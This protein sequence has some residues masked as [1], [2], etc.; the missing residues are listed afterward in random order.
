[1]KRWIAWIVIMV[2][3]AAHAQRPEDDSRQTISGALRRFNMAEA[4]YRIYGQGFACRLEQL[5]P[6][7]NGVTPSAQ[8][9]GLINEELASGVFA[10]YQ[11]RLSCTP[12][13]Y[14]VIAVPLSGSAGS[15]WCVD[16]SFELRTADSADR[17]ISE[18][19]IPPRQV[20]D[21][22]DQFSKTDPSVAKDTAARGYWVDSSD[23]LMWAGRDSGKEGSWHKATNYCRGL[24]LAGYSDWRLATIDELET[25]VNLP[26][27]ATEYVG[28]SDFMHRNGHLEVS[29]GLVLT[30]GRQW[31][32]TPVIE[33]NGR[34][35]GVA[36]W[37]FWFD[38]GRKWRGYESSLEGDSMNALCVRNVSVH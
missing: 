25:L 21:N 24:R 8:G 29:G 5:G 30:Y 34:A 2:C 17:C 32:S 35:S 4:L 36:F 33:A 23:G 20:R 11:I 6:P 28:A 22:P 1:M 13:D 19:K 26:A 3:G 10:G 38:E 16:K 31:S 37:S 27:Y 14:Q 9:A 15:A 18:G 7:R 12:S